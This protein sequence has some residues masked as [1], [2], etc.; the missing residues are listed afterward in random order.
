[1]MLLRAT[2]AVRLRGRDVELYPLTG[3][4]PDEADVPALDDPT[5]T[6]HDGERFTAVVAVVERET[7]ARAHAGVVDDHR[8]A[9]FGGVATAFFQH[10]SIEF[11]R[12]LGRDVDL[13]LVRV[14][15]EHLGRRDV[16]LGGLAADGH[17]QIFGD[18]RLGRRVSGALGGRKA[19]RRR[20]FRTAARSEREGDES[21]DGECPT[22]CDEAIAGNRPAGVS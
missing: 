16:G 21:R 8:V 9:G 4:R 5:L 1:M 20:G 19:H 11:G 15:F 13:G 2:V 3:L 7:I 12:C 18:G 6:E 14:R 22:H 10:R 17:T